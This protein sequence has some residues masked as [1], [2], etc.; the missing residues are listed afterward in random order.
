M[1]SKKETRTFFLQRGALEINSQIPPGCK[2]CMLCLSFVQQVVIAGKQQ[3]SF[4]GNH[5]HGSQEGHPGTAAD[6][7]ALQRV[8]YDPLLTRTRVSRV[9][10]AYSTVRH[11]SSRG[12]DTTNMLNMLRLGRIWLCFGILDAEMSKKRRSLLDF[13]QRGRFPPGQK[14]RYTPDF[15]DKGEKTKRDKHF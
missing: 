6:A 7:L 13:K 3:E 5:H 11:E 15:K 14:K 8:P 2:C 4:Q 10:K 1:N 12:V 9:L